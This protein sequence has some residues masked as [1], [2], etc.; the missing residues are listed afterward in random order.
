M[1]QHRNPRP[2]LISDYDVVDKALLRDGVVGGFVGRNK[3]PG[4]FTA[5]VL[6]EDAMA[7]L[8]LGWREVI[9]EGRHLD[10]DFS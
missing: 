1:A 9:R 2:E 5:V 3:E 4:A 8:M 6:D 7:L 10:A